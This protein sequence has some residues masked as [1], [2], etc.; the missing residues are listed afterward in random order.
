M[1]SKI[2]CRKCQG[3]HLTIKC[4]LRNKNKTN[5][6]NNNSNYGNNRDNRNNR[7][8]KNK[9]LLVK[10]YPLP[11]DLSKG[12]LSGLLREWGPIGKIFFK[13]QYKTKFQIA[14]IE[15]LNY[16]NG[17]KAIYQLNK[18]NFDYMLINVEQLTSK[19]Y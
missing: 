19:N 2:T 4:P 13:K 1:E 15:F 9:G 18:T 8:N 3:E 16:D 17:L 11:H 10:M 6:Q 12:E 7:N 5:H 14:T